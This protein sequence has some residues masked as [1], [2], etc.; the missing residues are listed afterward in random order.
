[1]VRQRVGMSS[2]GCCSRE[3]GRC[4]VSP[5]LWYKLRRLHDNI[6]I[7]PSQHSAIVETRTICY[8]AFFNCHSRSHHHIITA[9]QHGIIDGRGPAAWLL[10]LLELGLD[11]NLSILACK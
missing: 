6:T 10:R 5:W 7:K 4:T 8:Q 9:V 2:A 11:Q 1:M 3:D